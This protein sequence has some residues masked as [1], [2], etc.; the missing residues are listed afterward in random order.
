[1]TGRPP[2]GRSE[3]STR[4]R[5]LALAVTGVLVL[6]APALTWPLMPDEA[7]FL[8]VARHWDPGPGTL[9]GPLW[10]DRPPVLIGTYRVAD[11]LLGSYGV[12]LVSALLAVAAV[13]AAHRL[14]TALGGARAA[15]WSTA[16]A[17]ILLGW[18]TL[19]TWAGKSESL[20]V[21]LVLVACWLAVESTRRT[22]RWSGLAT[23]LAAGVAATLAVGM[24]QNLVGGVVFIAVLMTAR[25]VRGVSPRRPAALLLGATVVGGA[26]PLVIVL[27]WGAR[28]GVSPQLLWDV[29][30]GFRADAY[31]VISETE[32]QANTARALRL[33]GLA[34]VTGIVPLLGWFVLRL[35]PALRRHP[36]V[37]LALLAVI[38]VD[39]AGVVLGGS[40]WDS[41][42]QVFTPAAVL[43]VA[44]LSTMPGSTGAVPRLVTVGMVVP[45]T[46]S[47]VTGATPSATQGTATGTTVGRAVQAAAAPDDTIVV[48]HGAPNVVHASGLSTP[49]RHLWSLPRRTLDPDLDELHAV[50]T[51]PDAPT[52]IVVVHAVSS[53]GLDEDGRVRRTIGSRYE[54]HGT[55]CGIDVWVLRAEDRPPLPPSDCER[56]PSPRGDR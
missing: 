38:A 18:T 27:L 41:Y 46:V 52:W 50:L 42:L 54:R 48:M 16:V 5:Q 11:A 49:Y 51:G 28:V 9:Y 26:L 31:A 47:L 53:W 45:L 1:M 44:L 21:P 30:L 35:V 39:T 13:L 34:V 24:K 43:V 32:S 6:S 2:S 22:E 33:V 7:G 40:Y 8:L 37:G 14:G 4:R 29:L 15:A 12:R 23:A 36:E 56:P 25:L 17:V 10:V 3:R 55:V 20:G 19:A